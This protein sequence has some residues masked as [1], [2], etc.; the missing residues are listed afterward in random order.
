M[1]CQRIKLAFVCVL[2][3]AIAGCRQST[4]QFSSDAERFQYEYESMNGKYD[5]HGHKMRDLSIPVENPMVY[6][7]F[8]DIIQRITANETF[9]VYFGYTK[10]PWCR[11]NIEALL[12]SAAECG[13]NVIYYV[14]VY[15]NRDTYEINNGEPTKVKDGAEG[16]N[17][18]LE[19]LGP[20]LQDY[21]LEDNNGNSINT[22]EKRIYAPNVIVVKDGTAVG[23]ASDSEA[24]QDAYGDITDEAFSEIRQNYIDLFALLF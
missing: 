6:S 9:V 24:F 10:C 11:G 12:T 14:D 19:L 23:I 22:G 2:L 13:L 16:Y 17:E 18:L 15:T 5:D 1:K 20:V 7:S 8:S 4:P 3:L 21:T